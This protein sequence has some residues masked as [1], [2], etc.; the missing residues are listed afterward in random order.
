MAGPIVIPSLAN[1]LA[2]GYGYWLAI[3]APEQNYIAGI[4]LYEYTDHLQPGWHMMGSVAKETAFIDPDDNPDGA[5]IAAFGWDPISQSYYPTTTLLPNTGYW[6]A[7][8]EE[9]DLTIG[10]E[11]SLAKTQVIKNLLLYHFSMRYA[12]LLMYA[13]YI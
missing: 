10:E 2:T 9:C 11:I 5:V 13:H 4:P 1:G 8:I 6:I 12:L 7:V 3:P